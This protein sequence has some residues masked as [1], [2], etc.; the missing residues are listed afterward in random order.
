[1]TNNNP[2]HLE[3]DFTLFRPQIAGIRKRVATR[4]KCGLAT[5]G[6]LS[7]GDDSPRKEVWAANLSE[8]GIGFYFD[9]P[10]ETGMSLVI[11]LS[12]RGQANLELVAKVIHATEQKKDSWLIGCEFGQRLQPEML[13]DVL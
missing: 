2:V 1:M 12:R 13:D 9:R 7:F 5:L 11:S 10:L 6:Y 8:S 3:A 4:Y